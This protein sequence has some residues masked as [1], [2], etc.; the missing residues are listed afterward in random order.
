M[1]LIKGGLKREISW[2]LFPFLKLNLCLTSTMN[3]IL[4]PQLLVSAL[5][6]ASWS[7]AE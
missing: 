7:H 6:C 5:L 4:G 1:T 2:T 3:L